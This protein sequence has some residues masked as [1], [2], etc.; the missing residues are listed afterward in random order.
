ME[1]TILGASGFAVITTAA[2]WF[3]QGWRYRERTKKEKDE[4]ADRLEIHKDELTF[5]LL[6]SARTEMNA[7]KNEMETLRDEVRTL[8]ALEQHFYHFEQ[9]LDHLQAVLHAKDDDEVKTARRNATAFLNRM[10]RLAEAKGTIANEVQR[11]E[12][13]VG[14]TEKTLKDIGDAGPSS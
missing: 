3:G 14:M 13:T 2:A 8:R 6:Q 7:T 1:V 11:A 9:S 5:Q 12:S 4:Q 10:R